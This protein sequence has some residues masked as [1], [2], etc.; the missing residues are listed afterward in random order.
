MA[1][2]RLYTVQDLEQSPP[3]GE[4]ELIDGE[5]VPM[6]P[7]SLES[8]SLGHRIGRIVGNFVDAHDLGMMT[9]ADGGY[10]LFPDRE[11]LRVPDVGFIRKDRV[12]PVAE[13][14]RFARLAPDLVVE[15]LSPSDRM[16]DALS[17]VAMYLQAGVRLVWLIDPDSKTITVFRPDAAPRTMGLGDTLDGGD[18]LPDF[19]VPVAEIFA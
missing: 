3:E 14:S 10:V 17:K 1:V 13:R 9:G 4:W 7:S 6:T 11:T 2:A 18:V 12:P 5:L 19:G 8:S 15:V 16:V